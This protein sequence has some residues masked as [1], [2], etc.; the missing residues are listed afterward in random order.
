M[1]TCFCIA[2][3][4]LLSCVGGAAV[5]GDGHSFGAPKGASGLPWVTAAV[6]AP[7]VQF[8]VFASASVGENVSYHVFLPEAYTVQPTRRF[9]VLYWLHG[10]NAG[11]TGVA[12]VAA[13]FNQAMNLGLIPPMIIVFPNGLPNGMWCDALSGLQP[14]ES[15]LVQDL[16]PEVERQFRAI[17][18]ARGRLVEG[19]S[20]GGYGAARIGL[21]YNTLFAGFSMLG[22]GPLQLDFLQ[23]GPNFQPI[24]VRRRILNEVY[25]GDPAHFEAQSPWRLAEAVVGALPSGYPVRQLI[26]TLDFTLQPNRDFHQRLEQIALPHVYVEV[27]GVDHSALAIMNSMGAA[28]WTFHQLALTPLNEDVFNDGFEVLP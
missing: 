17:P 3:T 9:P 11:T 25:G 26:G 15:M 12:P 14:V 27:P 18:R 22:A 20:M 8:R 6:T 28:F 16:I 4:L 21:K 19:F 7:Q 1:K 2:L 10:S 13:R 5:S 24:E 23:E